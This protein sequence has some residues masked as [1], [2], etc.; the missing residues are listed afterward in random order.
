MKTPPNNPD[1][2]DRPPSGT[3]TKVLTGVLSASPKDIQETRER[4]KAEKFSSRKR[5]RY[6]PAKPS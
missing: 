5:F 6:V 4:A 2:L 1:K 3:F